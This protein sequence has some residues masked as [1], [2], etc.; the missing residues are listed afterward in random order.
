MD[1]DPEQRLGARDR[2]E[3]RNHPFFAGIDWENLERKELT[4]PKLDALAADDIEMPLVK[5]L[6]GD[7]LIN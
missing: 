5:I 7:L 2:N 6:L 4:P 1:R 3:L